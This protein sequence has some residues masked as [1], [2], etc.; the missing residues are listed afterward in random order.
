MFDNFRFSK[1]LFGYNKKQVEECVGSLNS[2]VK[3]LQ[4]RLDKANKAMAE[5]KSEFSTKSQLMENNHKQLKEKYDDLEGAVNKKEEELVLYKEQKQAAYEALAS[6]MKDVASL[7]AEQNSSAEREQMLLQ[8]ISDLNTK[9]NDFR[10]SQAEAEQL[11][12]ERERVAEALVLANEKA[13]S[14]IAEAENNAKTIIENAVADSIHEKKRV[15]MQVEME[16]EKLI[17]LKKEIR[18]LKG[19]FAA[20]MSKF[21]DGYDTL[22]IE[23]TLPETKQNA[24]V[25]VTDTAAEPADDYQAESGNVQENVHDNSGDS[26]LGIPELPADFGKNLVPDADFDRESFI[27]KA[28]NMIEFPEF[29]EEDAD[30]ADGVDGFDSGISTTLL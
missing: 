23:D 13:D 14:I 22:N 15:E 25:E 4:D 16:R 8:Q 24:D 6:T 5:Q 20:L 7:K 19:N 27:R 11:N 28:D 9:I 26:S 29:E 10:A 30:G 3:D 2:Q 17:D 12:A 21:E 18:G 1:G